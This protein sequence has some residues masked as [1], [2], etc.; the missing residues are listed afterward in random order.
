MDDIDMDDSGDIKSNTNTLSTTR[1]RDINDDCSIP[2]SSSLDNRIDT[3]DME[4]NTQS[5]SGYNNFDDLLNQ[6][7]HGFNALNTT[8]PGKLKLI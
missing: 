8:D 4:T 5:N 3:G 7:T 1:K 2:S 6:L